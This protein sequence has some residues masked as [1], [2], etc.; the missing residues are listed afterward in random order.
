MGWATYDESALNSTSSLGFVPL[1]RLGTSLETGDGNPVE[2]R[3]YS[4][5]CHDSP[6]SFAAA[7]QWSCRSH[8]LVVF[9]SLDFSLALHPP[10]L[11]HLVCFLPTCAAS[12]FDNTG[13]PDPILGCSLF[14]LVQRPIL[15]KPL[16]AHIWGSGAIGL[17]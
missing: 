3:E 7:R 5:L 13:Q 2:A 15:P 9:C 4:L 6:L 14:P 11:R 12:I 8:K 10:A 17:S 1:A 16:R